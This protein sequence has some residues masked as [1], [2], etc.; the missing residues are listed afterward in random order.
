MAEILEL[1]NLSAVAIDDDQESWSTI[2]NYCAVPQ[3]EPET[4]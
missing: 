4:V 2:S 3:G 1:Q